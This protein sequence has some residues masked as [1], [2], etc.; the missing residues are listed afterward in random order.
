MESPWEPALEGIRA[1]AVTN[2][3]GQVHLA[4]VGGGIVGLF[5]ALHYVRAHP[6]HRVLVVERGRASAGASVKNAGFACFGSPSELL[7]DADREGTEAMLV[8]VEER[9][10]GL[11]ELRRELGDARIGFEATGGHEV[12]RSNDPLYPRVAER[13]SWLNE[14]LRNVIGPGVYRWDPDAAHRFGLTGIS[15]VARTGLEGPVHSGKLVR[16][17]WQRTQEAGVRHSTGFAVRSIEERSDGAWILSTDGRALQAG[18]VVVATNGYARELFPDV[19]ITPARGQVLLTAPIPRLAL[20]GTFHMDEGFYYF[21]DHEGGVLL[22]GGRNLDLAGESTT[23]DRVTAPIQQA[24]E[25]LLRG[26]ILP[27]QKVRVVR[28]WSGIMGFRT[29]GKNPLVERR[30]ERVLIAAGL[31]GMGVAIGVRVARHAARLAGE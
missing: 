28:R 15:H 7:A 21:R 14:Q 5:T 12:Y 29:H 4:V 8:R 11:L 9:W 27:G 19:D 20:R 24:L 10:Q 16:T 22:G 18:Q 25:E 26:T 6:H 2:E 23:D 30:S 17:L 1:G 31:S 3:P 13:F